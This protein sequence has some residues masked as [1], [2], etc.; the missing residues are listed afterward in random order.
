MS[1]KQSGSTVEQGSL[2][3]RIEEADWPALAEWLQ[4]NLPQKTFLVGEQPTTTTTTNACGACACKTQKGEKDRLVGSSCSCCC[5]STT[6]RCREQCLIPFSFQE[7]NQLLVECQQLFK[8]GEESTPVGIREEQEEE[9]EENGGEW[10]IVE[11][12]GLIHQDTYQPSKRKRSGDQGFFARWPSFHVAR[13]LGAVMEASGTAFYWGCMGGVLFAMEDICFNWSISAGYLFL[14]GS[15]LPRWWL[16]SSAACHVLACAVACGSTLAAPVVVVGSAGVFVAASV[17][18]SF[19]AAGRG[20]SLLTT[21]SCGN[22][23]SSTPSLSSS[24]L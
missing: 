20:L 19:V 21:A 3:V 8:N 6:G 1:D 16:L 10:V 9:E 4:A 2:Y 13:R 24:A 18:H 14:V 11:E 5:C 7:G 17:Y 22:L 23:S 15:S 12:R